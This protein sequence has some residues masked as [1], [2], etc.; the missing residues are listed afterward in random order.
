MVALDKG[1]PED[2]V[3]FLEWV[4]QVADRFEEAWKRQTPPR[5]AEFLAEATGEQRAA[6]V[7]ELVRI[8]R[9]RRA[10]VGQDRSW[11]EYQR[12]FPELGG[13]AEV[14]PD[15]QADYQTLKPKGRDTVSAAYGPQSAPSGYE[16]LGELGHGGMG[17]V[18]Q[19]RQ[20]SLKRLVA[21]KVIRSGPYTEPQQLAR[22]RAEAEA[23]AGLQH[24]NIVQI[25]EIGEQDGWPYFSLEYM[26]GGSLAAR[27]AGKPQPP[28]AA[29]QLV[30]T[31]ARAV[32]FAHERGIIHRDLK[33]ANILLVRRETPTGMGS[34]VAGGIE[35]TEWVPKITDFGLAKHREA[36]EGQTQ[37]GVIMG[38]PNYMA[39]EQAE[40]KA[41]QV[42]PT[43]DV[44]ALG[45]ILY[46]M[47]TGRPPFQGETVWETLEQ[48]RNEEPIAPTRLQPRL[49]RDLETIC[50]KSMAKN[51]ARRYATAGQLADDLGRF[52]R[53]EPIQARPVGAA[54]RVWR[55]CRRYPAQAGLVATATALVLAIVVASSLIALASTA[56]ERDRSRE[57]LVQGLQLIRAQS[58]TDGWSCEAWELV[59]AAAKLRPDPQ[60][61]DQA[62]GSCADLDAR[63]VKFFEK[64]GVSALAFD[65]AGRFLLMGGSND[66]QGQ[67]REG[68]RLWDSRTS[69]MLVSSEMGAGPVAFGRNGQPLHLAIR[70]GPDLL[71]C[72]PARQALVQTCRLPGKPGA[73][74]VAVNDLG[75]PVL[76]LAPDGG[77]LA[78]ALHQPREDFVAVWETATGRLLFRI[79]GPAGALVFAPACDVLAVGDR[80]GQVTLW[81]LPGGKVAG[82]FRVPRVTIHCLAFTSRGDRLGVG[83]SAGTVTVWD[84][85]SKEPVTYCYGSHHDVYA[86]AFSPDGTLL[87]SG[88]GGPVGL[89]DAAT[90]RMVLSLRSQGQVTSL[91]FAPDGRRLAVGN[92][93]PARVAVWELEYGRGIRTL[94]GLSSQAAHVCFSDDSRWLAALGHNN[95][96]AIWDL[97]SEQL[98]RLLEAPRGRPDDAAA[99]AFSPDGRRFAC[100][101]GEEAR[102]WD[103]TICQ[104]LHSWR[105]PA[106]SNDLLAFHPSGA[107]LLFRVE[108]GEAEPQPAGEENELE[109]P[110]VGRIR[111]LLGPHPVQPLFEITQFNRHFLDAVAAPDGAWFIVEGV[112]D[113]PDGLRRSIKAFDGITGAERWSVASRKTAPAGTLVLDADGNHL[114]VHLDNG[115]GG[116][117]LNAASG[118]IR[119]ALPRYPVCMSPAIEYLV[120]LGPQASSG[121]ERDFG[122]LRRGDLKPRLIL[123]PDTVPAFRPAFSRTGHLLAWSNADGTVSVADLPQV[124]QRLAEVRLAWSNQG[125]P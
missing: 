25:Y 50:L 58:H 18:Y 54:E 73:A 125:D 79:P 62:A 106:G 30:E 20:L 101:A 103:L 64:A 80:H 67:A 56:R 118:Q 49:P 85:A 21:L 123:G 12:E 119:E 77:C 60:L 53:R 96:L 15:A 86:L 33:P 44:Y 121:Q 83:D 29:A 46:E 100:A 82:T 111:N 55:W 108:K 102:L 45:A 90:G 124:Q 95:L 69:T 52:C 88:G 37:S 68:A 113:G 97:E 116:Q 81:S 42:G 112:H 43:A 34:A 5:I 3:A 8:D 115:E 72:D 38:T 9:Q 36:E 17:T 13:Q 114:A 75:L 89:W 39:P 63:E 107:L 92:R 70:D 104:Q 110:Q 2:Q 11:D 41:K 47:L 117:L 31:V 27:L 98:V 74:T 84:W 94:R 23:A 93:N 26:D 71:V 109:P 59:I 51:P 91:A 32:H 57:A 66:A 87:A 4:D 19:A 40:G 120:E 1:P 10:K 99:L 24:P 78:A 6:L 48:V 76:A 105:L 122:L 61:R 14:R 22:F 7:T 65:A 28:R 16:I 35:L